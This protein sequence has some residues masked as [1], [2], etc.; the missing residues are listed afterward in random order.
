[1][2][3]AIDAT[4]TWLATLDALAHEMKPLAVSR[5]NAQVVKW[6]KSSTSYLF[7]TR[8]L[9]LSHPIARTLTH[10]ALSDTRTLKESE[11][12]DEPSGVQPSELALRRSR[13]L[14]QP[15]YFRTLQTAVEPGAPERAELGHRQSSAQTR[16][17]FHNHRNELLET[18]LADRPFAKSGRFAN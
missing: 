5:R 14:H 15:S 4:T 11:L 10:S 9:V 16:R 2:S 3:Q 12:R 17:K 6:T 1:M 8:L 18:V 13:R 7:E